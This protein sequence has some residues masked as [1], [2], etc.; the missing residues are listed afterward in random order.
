MTAILT[1]P[2][3]WTDLILNGS[4]THNLKKETIKDQ[5]EVVSLKH[6]SSMLFRKVETNT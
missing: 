4:E 5:Y 2:A 1:K 6:T 3:H